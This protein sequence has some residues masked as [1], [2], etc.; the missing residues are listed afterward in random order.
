MF[1]IL[2]GCTIL[3]LYVAQALGQAVITRFDPQRP[4]RSLSEPALMAAADGKV[5]MRLNGLAGDDKPEQWS[6]VYVLDS[7]GRVLR[8][9]EL[10][11]DGHSVVVPYRAGFVSMQDGDA[12]LC[13]PAGSDCMP[14]R[15]DFVYHDLSRP[16]LEPV[17]LDSRKGAFHLIG[18][19]DRS[20]LYLIGAPFPY[21][22]CRTRS[23]SRGST[24]ASRPCGRGRSA[25]SR[26]A[27]WSRP[28][29]ALLSPST[30]KL[31]R[32]ATC[33]A[34]S[35]STARIAGKSRCRTA[36]LQISSTCPPGISSFRRA[37]AS[38]RC[39]STL[40]PGRF[41]RTSTFRTG[42]SRCRRRMDCWSSGGCSASRTP[43]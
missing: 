27:P 34:Q 30:R 11:N 24:Q 41:F 21:R 26:S 2:A 22:K 16:G 10:P 9:F 25:A 17:I 7:Q 8:Q 29:T 28:T 39:G 35:V 33:S 31:P 6:A 15:W 3:A 42:T 38:R 37:A 4:Y 5:L 14:E 18:S 20:N 23:A 13:H 1:K 40:R 19:P 36:R 43:G 32:C 12:S